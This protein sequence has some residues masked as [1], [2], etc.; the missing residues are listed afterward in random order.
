[1]RSGQKRIDFVSRSVERQRVRSSFRWDYILPSH[2]V[3]IDDV[4][5]AGIANGHVEAPE[6]QIEEY[7]I[8]RATQ[9]NIAE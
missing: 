3:D 1:M 7:Y 6:F 2:R 5:D 8:R 4:D 9:G